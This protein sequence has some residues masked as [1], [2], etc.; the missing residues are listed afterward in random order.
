MNFE[1]S[2]ENAGLISRLEKTVASGKISHAYLIEASPS[3]DKRRFAKNF[4]KGIL[5]PDG[6]GENCGKCSICRKVDHDSHEDVFFIEK[7]GLSVKDEMIEKLQEKLKIRPFGSRNI[8]V[9]DDSDTMTPRAQNRLLKT[10]EEPPGDS[11]IFL[12]CDNM[13]NLAQTVRSRCVRFRINSLNGEL[14]SST[15]KNREKAQAIAELSL[16]GGRFYEMCAVLGMK[17]SI[18]KT[19]GTELLDSIQEVYR[20]MIIDRGNE[21]SL[22]KDEDAYDFIHSAESA[23]RQINEGVKADYAVRRFLLDICR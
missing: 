16:K 10:L 11:V 13:E 15:K 22:L 4:I 6:R 5:C 20:N 18:S 9:I 2:R 23:K 21:I 8:A 7:A 14:K 3:F 17:N 12:L 19:D 1:S